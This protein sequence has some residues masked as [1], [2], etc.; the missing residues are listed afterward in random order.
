M[1]DLSSK[2]VQDIHAL[3]EGIYQKEE[4]LTE[5]Q[6]NE[7][8]AIEWYNALV[9]GGII[10]GELITENPGT[11]P[12]LWTKLGNAIQSGGPK[13][14]RFLRK[15]TGFGLG[16]DVGQKRR[17]ITTGAGTATAIDPEKAAQQVGG[18]IKGTSTVLQGAVRGGI[19]AATKEKEEAKS[20]PKAYIDPA[21]GTI[22]YTN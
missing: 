5:E 11:N 18:A 1:S 6:S 20:N 14:M 7:L 10:D 8:L 22:K 2:K 9:E 19:D 13:V 12:G 4:T 16:K 3:Y 17:I 15:T 21:T